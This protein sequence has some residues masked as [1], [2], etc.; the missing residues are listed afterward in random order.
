MSFVNTRATL[1]E[2]ETLDK[3][4]ERSLTELKEDGIASLETYALYNNTALQT[5][6][7][8]NITNV[9]ANSMQGCTGLTTVKLGGEGST[10]ALTIA[11]SAFSGCSNLAHL[12]I[13]RPNKAT[14]SNMSALT[15]TKIAL[16]NGAVYVRE[17]QLATYKADANW[18]NYFIAKLAD[19]PRSNF[20]S[21]E[22][23]WSTIIAN[24]DYDSDYAIGDTK[25]V[26]V[27]GT[28]MKMILI[29]KDADV[30]S[31]DHTSK[32]RMTWLC[33]SI[34]TTHRMNA[35]S[36]TSGGWGS[37][38]I[39]TWLRET[40]FPT[41]PAELRTAIV[42]VDKTYRSKSP[43]DET[44]T[45]AD[46]IWIP[47][48]KEVGFTNAA[49]VESD[50]VV[51]SVFNSNANRIKYNASGSA[52]VWWL[53]SAYSAAGFRCVYNGGNE[54]NNSANGTN[55]VVFGFCI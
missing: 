26:S 44:L 2:Q 19:Y 42:E 5:V 43:N 39:R 53:R 29:A 51:Y 37:S 17:D 20:D 40:I 15:G 16:G 32:A 21:I 41:L 28:T 33:N 30:K 50:G 47:S 14:L 7:F 52:A 49:Y 27:N 13:D 34:L 45:I 22:D 31:S 24:A 54:S 10:G 38:E 25:T 1:G 9:K 18:K 48:Y 12:L 11:A 6:E 3:L 8:P 55:G 46:T 36:D 23:D 4:V 35:T